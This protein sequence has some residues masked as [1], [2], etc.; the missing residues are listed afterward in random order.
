[1]HWKRRKL[2]LLNFT[3]MNFIS[4]TYCFAGLGFLSAAEPSHPVWPDLAPGEAVNST[5][6]Q[7]SSPPHYEP[8]I[9]LMTKVT[10]PTFTVHP[11]AVPNGTGLVILPGGGFH[12]V[13][14]DL[15]GTEAVEFLNRIGVTVFVLSYRTKNSPE[16]SG[17]E[18]PLQD[19]Q[20]MMALIRSRAAQW[21]LD[22]NK[23]G[24]LGFS[25]G[26]QVAARLLSSNGKLAYTPVD[27]I[28][29]TAH[30]PDFALLIYPWGVYDEDKDGLIDGVS[31]SKSYPP[32]F[33]VH[34]DDD[35][36]SSLGS[37]LLYAGLKKH[38]ISAE[39]HVYGNGGHGYGVRPQRNSEI[40]T[41]P[42]H[43][44]HWLDRWI[45]GNH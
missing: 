35:R 24:L 26:G 30:R 19:S 28:D 16:E 37:V 34:T 1:M 40:S 20:R 33:I 18:K 22:K 2:N 21:G 27:D 17:W 9:T 14:P 43:A 32:T 23:I 25:A 4:W 11:A 38:G 13:V 41:W 3:T 45:K 44:G 8:P 36:S 10:Q 39:L 7:L 6:L 5:G 15:E 42:R 31:V 29:T 12:R